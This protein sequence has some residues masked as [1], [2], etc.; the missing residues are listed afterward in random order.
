L[1]H[2]T[3]RYWG[4]GVNEAIEAATGSDV[5]L[6]STTI[7]SGLAGSPGIRGAGVALVLSDT[8]VAKA[9]ATGLWLAS[10]STTVVIT[11]NT[12]RNNS[13]YGIDQG[14]NPSLT[15]SGSHF[16]D[17][18]MNPVRIRPEDVADLL[19]NNNTFSRSDGGENVLLLRDGDLSR[20]TTLGLDQGLTGYEQEANDTNVPAGITLTVK[21]GVVFKAQ[22][23]ARITV[24][25]RL[26]A[27]GTATQP[28]TF[29]SPPTPL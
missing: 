22:P 7:I 27:R 24:R 4:S 12:F 23:S 21:P 17:N 2:V 9:G 8:T 15:I 25:G 1:A 26:Q 29:W 19:E 18:G 16:A 20:D 10:D 6:T 13:G 3:I 14:A 11:N 5:R 28:I